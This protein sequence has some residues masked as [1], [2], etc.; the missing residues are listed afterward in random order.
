[1]HT[2]TGPIFVEADPGHYVDLAAV[3]EFHDSPEHDTLLICLPAPSIASK[4]FNLKA[5]DGPHQLVLSGESRRLAL[6]YF[7]YRIAQS[8]AAFAAIEHE[9]RRELFIELE[10]TLPRSRAA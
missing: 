8:Q 4:E 5:G 2:L 3:F 1:M 10:A 7:N 6:K 9:K